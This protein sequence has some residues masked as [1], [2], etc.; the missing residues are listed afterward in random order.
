MQLADGKDTSF[1]REAHNE[2]DAPGQRHDVENG[3][4]PDSRRAEGARDGRIA[5]RSAGVSP[6]S[7][8]SSSTFPPPHGRRARL[9]GRAC[10]RY[11]PRLGPA[12]GLPRELYGH[13]QL[14]ST[15]AGACPAATAASRRRGRSPVFDPSGATA[16][17]SRSRV[18]IS[19]GGFRCAR[20]PSTAP[21][22]SPSRRSTSCA[23]A[24]RCWLM[25][26]PF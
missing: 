6:A 17:W 3:F 11:A 20:S 24:A 7:A 14:H 2:P 21:P 4:P 9:G 1:S 23:P 19:A 13:R 22:S 26:R 10:R 5:C 18:R 16:V 15:G 8:S 12:A 25:V